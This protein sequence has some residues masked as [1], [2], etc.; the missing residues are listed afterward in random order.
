MKLILRMVNEKQ[1]PS[2]TNSGG[3]DQLTEEV[4]SLQ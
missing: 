3:T 2:D 1:I 4:E